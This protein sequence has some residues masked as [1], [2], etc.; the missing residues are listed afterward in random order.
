MAV[1]IMAL[2]E[3]VRLPDATAFNV[4]VCDRN[5]KRFGNNIIVKVTD[6]PE[7]SAYNLVFLVTTEQ[8]N[9]ILNY[10]FVR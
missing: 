2:S 5:G 4:V 1:P 9:M 3:D 8:G 7:A 10:S 6:K